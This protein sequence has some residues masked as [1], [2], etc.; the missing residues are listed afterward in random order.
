[1]CCSTVDA[2][3]CLSHLLVF[4]ISQVLQ[5]SL[6]L[7]RKRERRKSTLRCGKKKNT[8]QHNTTQQQQKRANDHCPCLCL[9]L[10]IISLPL[11]PR[12]K[13][14][15]MIKYFLVSC[16]A[17]GQARYFPDMKDFV[18]MKKKRALSVW[19][20]ACNH[21]PIPSF[22]WTNVSMHAP[23]TVNPLPKQTPSLLSSVQ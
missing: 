8:T 14:A 20:K 7:K 17:F 12:M 15:P 23:H 19:F 6:V 4:F 11:L 3:F 9:S 2:L 18:C 5:S 10:C 13:L 22:G 21:L 16:L 1:M